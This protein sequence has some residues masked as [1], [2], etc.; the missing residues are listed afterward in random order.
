MSDTLHPSAI[1]GWLDRLLC[2]V[3]NPQSALGNQSQPLTLE[4]QNSCASGSPHSARSRRAQAPSMG[5]LPPAG[6]NLPA[7]LR[8]RTS[9][10]NIPVVVVVVAVLAKLT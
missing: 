9:T 2:D 5:N 1:H 4:H 8:I 7:F 6:A 3:R 10:V